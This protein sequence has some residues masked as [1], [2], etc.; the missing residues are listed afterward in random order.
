MENKPNYIKEKEDENV[1]LNLNSEY[2]SKDEITL[3]D[4][5]I[6]SSGYSDSGENKS[7][8]ELYWDLNKDAGVEEYRQLEITDAMLRINQKSNFF[9]LEFVFDSKDFQINELHEFLSSYFSINSDNSSVLE[10]RIIPESMEGEMMIIARNPF[11]SSTS[12]TNMENLD[13]LQLLFLQSEVYIGKLDSKD[14]KWKIE[15]L[16]INYTKPIIK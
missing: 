9:I 12:S 5:V 3:G 11:L 4:M 1:D 15:T 10:V 16:P 7:R 6:A 2:K 14:I 13:V 8:V